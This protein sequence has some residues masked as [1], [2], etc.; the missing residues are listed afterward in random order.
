[1][2]GC[3]GR[4]ATP[5]ET[6]CLSCGRADQ[7]R[8]DPDPDADLLRGCVY[9]CA[10]GDGHIRYPAMDDAWVFPEY[11]EP[12]VSTGGRAARVAQEAWARARPAEYVPWAPAITVTCQ[13]G[14]AVTATINADAQSPYDPTH[15]GTCAC[16]LVYE[17]KAR[18]VKRPT[19]A[20]ELAAWQAQEPPR[21]REPLRW[22][23]DGELPPCD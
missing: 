23:E 18:P 9:W 7:W 3:A 8:H 20:A 21:R 14:A 19:Y 12:M 6:P 4:Y 13:C 2:T 15:T 5:C 11:A 10:C 17:L 22:I 16:G 1:M